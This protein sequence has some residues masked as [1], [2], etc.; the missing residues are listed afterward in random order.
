MLIRALWFVQAISCREGFQPA[1]DVTPDGEGASGLWI[2]D[3]ISHRD[4]IFE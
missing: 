3:L 1:V 2:G 4:A